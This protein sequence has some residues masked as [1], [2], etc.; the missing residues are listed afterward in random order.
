M[1]DTGVVSVLDG[2]ASG[3]SVGVALDAGCDSSGPVVMEGVADGASAGVFS[4]GVSG[5]GVFSEGRLAVGILSSTA[6]T[7]NAGAVVNS[8]AAEVYTIIFF[9]NLSIQRV[10]VVSFAAM[11]AAVY[12]HSISCP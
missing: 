8:I 9:I 4:A 11:K 2:V 1:P 10:V 5:A 7:D 12:F 3:D 6:D